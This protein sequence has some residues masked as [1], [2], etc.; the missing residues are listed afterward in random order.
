MFSG[1]AYP[2]DPVCVTLSHALCCYIGLL[3]IPRLFLTPFFYTLLF[4]NTG[5]LHLLFLFPHYSEGLTPHPSG[6][7]SNVAASEAPS[8]HPSSQPPFVSF[9]PVTDYQ[10]YLLICFFI[11][12]LHF[13]GC[14]NQKS[15]NHDHHCLPN[16]WDSAWATVGPQ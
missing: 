8:C 4:P 15:K 9:M 16:T 14:K 2:L 3:S 7:N 12:S 1:P 6:F 10:V 11:T 5:S 13:L